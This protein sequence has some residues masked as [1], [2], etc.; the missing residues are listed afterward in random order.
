M[1]VFLTCRQVITDSPSSS[2]WKKTAK[3]LLS[4][5]QVKE[6]ILMTRSSVTRNAAVEDLAWSP[7]LF[8]EIAITLFEKFLYI[9]LYSLSLL[10]RLLCSLP[11]RELFHCKSG[12]TKTVLL[13]PDNDNETDL[14]GLNKQSYGHQPSIS[15]RN[16]SI[17]PLPAFWKVGSL[18]SR[19]L[20]R[21]FL[22]VKNFQ[23]VSPQVKDLLILDDLI[24]FSEP[25]CST[26]GPEFCQNGEYSTSTVGD[27]LVS[28]A[29]P[30]DHVP[31]HVVK[32]GVTIDSMFDK[33]LAELAAPS[34]QLSS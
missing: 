31:D 27:M 24:D 25:V 7:A 17:S 2:I 10:L 13:N 26:E 28:E 29:M 5:L 18:R 16:I 30:A 1:L 11:F 22:Q 20:P 14:L 19:L 32:K 15:P 33:C 12:T 21:R 23:L 6:T 4:T 34:A 3:K 8:M 9:L